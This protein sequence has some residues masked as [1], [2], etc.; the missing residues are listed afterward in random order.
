MLSAQLVREACHGESGQRT[1]DADHPVVDQH[2]H[3]LGKIFLEAQPDQVTP[4]E[5]QELG[6]PGSDSQQA[7]ARPT[8]YSAD[9]EDRAPFLDP[10]QVAPAAR[11]SRRART[12]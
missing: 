7:A 11:R 2:G 3:L 4:G 9:R 5:L 10:A 1:A 12:G 8:A 6:G